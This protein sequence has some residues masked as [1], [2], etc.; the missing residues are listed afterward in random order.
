MVERLLRISKR[1]QKK[2]PKSS[3]IMEQFLGIRE[4]EPQQDPALQPV[5]NHRA[6]PHDMNPDWQDAL[7]PPTS[8]VS[9]SITHIE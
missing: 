4:P 8:A 6:L 3:L 1:E 2:W 9:G 7:C 5:Q